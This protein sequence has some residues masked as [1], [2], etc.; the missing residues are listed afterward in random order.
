MALIDNSGSALLYLL[1]RLFS[2]FRTELNDA[3]TRRQLRQQLESTGLLPLS[4]CHDGP[5]QAQG[6]VQAI[7][8][9]Q[10]PLSGRPVVG[11]RLVIEQVERTEIEWT[12]LV[13]TQRF[14]PFRLV[15][16]SDAALVDPSCAQL[17]LRPRR[18][19]I[20]DVLKLQTPVLAGLLQRE[21]ISSTT[22]VAARA[23]RATEYT[24]AAGDPLFLHGLGQRHFDP[25]VEP[26]NYR[27]APTTLHVRGSGAVPL[28]LADCRR[29][30]LLTT[31]RRRRP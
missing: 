9:L 15:D 31:L 24:L 29:G 14:N 2:L 22:L 23:L 12:T 16:E 11:Y 19:L 10:A 3:R 6:T 20:D 18:T 8:T 28:L 17:F 21:G 4:A 30:D 25:T 13:D 26:Q 5:L 1:R 27:A 7:A